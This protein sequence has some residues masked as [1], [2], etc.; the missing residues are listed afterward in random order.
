MAEEGLGHPEQARTAFASALGKS[1]PERV[2]VLIERKLK[3]KN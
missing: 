2:K 1:P 3:Q